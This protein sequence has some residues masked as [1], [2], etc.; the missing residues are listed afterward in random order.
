MLYIKKKKQRE[1]EKDK[2]KKKLQKVR[3]SIWCV[4]AL[5]LDMVCEFRVSEVR[6]E[7]YSK[8]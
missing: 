1:R 7:M 4:K 2:E 6:S 3:N 8:K 5:F